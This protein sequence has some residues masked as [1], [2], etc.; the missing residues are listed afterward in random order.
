V[1]VAIVCALMLF[2]QRALA[3]QEVAIEVPIAT[4]YTLAGKDMQVEDAAGTSVSQDHATLAL[5]GETLCPPFNTLQLPLKIRSLS[6]IS[7]NDRKLMGALWVI[8]QKAEL[9]LINRLPL[10]DYLVATVG[11]EMPKSFPPEALKAQ[12]VAARTYALSRKITREG[13]AAH[14]RSSTLDQVYGGLAHESKET[15]EAVSATA[16][17]VLV[18]ERQPI[19]AFF[20]S[21]CSGHTRDGATVFGGEYPYLKS[22]ECASCAQERPATWSTRQT[23][24][25]LERKLGTKVQRLEPAGKTVDGRAEAIVAFPSGKRFAP[26]II[27][28]LVGYTVVKSAD[29]SIACDKVACTLNG[30]GYGHGVGLCQHGAKGMA[31][32]GKTYRAILSHYYPGAV[33]RR[34]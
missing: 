5:C 11:S 30:T 2:T 1:R 4:V 25:D 32:A 14:L 15:R 12:A 26:E 19:E 28:K 7:V 31:K 22:V 29:F 10:E 16:G 23:L 6:P 20:F 9:V 18:Y 3:E 33:I 34:L 13:A 24:K 17:E 8:L 21:S 27:R